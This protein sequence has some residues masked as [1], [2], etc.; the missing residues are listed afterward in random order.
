MYTKIYHNTYILKKQMINLQTFVRAC[1]GVCARECMSMKLEGK[2]SKRK[3]KKNL[4]IAVKY[5]RV[6]VVMEC[7]TRVKTMHVK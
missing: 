6:K 2:G 4:H 7:D 1:V 5:L 3:K